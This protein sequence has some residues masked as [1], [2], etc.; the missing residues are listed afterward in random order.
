MDRNTRTM[1]VAGAVGA[2]VLAVAVGA[3]GAI[4]VTRALSEDGSRAVLEDDAPRLH[5]GFGF[6]P[7]GEFAPPGPYREIRPF[8]FPG[9]FG[10]LE[11]AA[12]YLGIREEQL[13]DELHEGMTLAEV[14]EEEG[15]SVAGLVD[16]MVA[17][18]EER[19]DEAVEDGRLNEEQATEL[20]REL[21]ESITGLVEGE[22]SER[23]F[24][25][26]DFDFGPGW[27]DDDRR[28]RGPEA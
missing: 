8:L 18:S 3:T 24:G 11:A 26:P 4:A 7:G 27:F 28:D 15:K 16:A 17:A 13:Y 19:I 5:R 25:R 20:R 1:L 6:G 21:E 2:L 12:A 9:V 23:P 14:A 10:G 22:R